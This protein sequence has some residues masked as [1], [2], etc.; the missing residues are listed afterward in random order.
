MMAFQNHNE[1][2][3]E[4]LLA[5]YVDGELASS[6][7]L[8][9]EAWIA[10]HPETAAAVEA[11][12]R[13]KQLWQATRPV[14]PDEAVWARIQ[15]II[16]TILAAP[17]VAASPALA[18]T[19]HKRA[20]NSSRVRRI[21]RWT[22]AVAA[23]LALMVL[24]A[25][26]PRDSSFAPTGEPYPVIA[27]DDID[28]ITVHAADAG[29]L[30]VGKPPLTEPLDIAQPGDVVVVSVKPDIDGMLPYVR[31]PAENQHVPMIVVPLGADIPREKPVP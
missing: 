6:E 5:A 19:A 23:F 22:S 31:S 13:F 11:L 7:Q 8:E 26:L 16:Q 27:T 28:I 3:R 14:E 12:R 30:V 18:V 15:N 20:S 9:L 10:S 4:E 24:D 25:R 17:H 29:R 1:P 2:P 21:V